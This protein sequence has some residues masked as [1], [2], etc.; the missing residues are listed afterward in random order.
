MRLCID[1]LVVSGAIDVPEFVRVGFKI[2]GV[3]D[4]S[5]LLVWLRFDDLMNDS[6][7]TC[8]V[9]QTAIYTHACTAH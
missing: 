8:E 1:I 3:D 4:V 7:V 5:I 2:C 6:L 9:R